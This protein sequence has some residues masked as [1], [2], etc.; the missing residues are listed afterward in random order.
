MLVVLPL[1]S[2][3][4]VCCPAALYEYSRLV[5]A[6]VPEALTCL[7]SCALAVV[8]LHG[9]VAQAVDH[10]GLLTGPVVRQGGEVA[11]RILFHQDPAQGIVGE[12]AHPAQRVGL[13]RDIAIA[14]IGGGCHATPGHR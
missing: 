12:R 5:S 11:R 10:A 7:V 3:W 8:S 6:A 13:G 2:R 1:A 4:A 14:V 9:A